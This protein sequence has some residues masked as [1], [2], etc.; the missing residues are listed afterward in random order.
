MHGRVG[1]GAHDVRVT[2]VPLRQP[3]VEHF[4]AARR[5]HHVRGLQIAVGQPRAVRGIERIRE[6]DRDPQ[7]VLEW[8]RAAQQPVGQRLARQI[9]HHQELD[10]VLLADVVQRADVRVR[11]A[12]DRA[13]F[14]PKAFL[15]PGVIGDARRQDLDRDGSIEPRVA[16][17]VDFA[18]AAGAERRHDF[19]RSQP[20]AWRQEH[21][22]C[23]SV[24]PPAVSVRKVISNTPMRIRSPSASCT[25]DVTAC[26]RTY[27]PFLLPRSSSVAISPVMT[28]LA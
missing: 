15:A 26:P 19:I 24:E 22:A 3:E 16:R 1:D 13:G 23:V 27:V 18:H 4:G 12:R 7:D 6:L 5:Q 2:A 17:F 11:Q 25:G 10:A 9:L 14:A 8:Q 21:G 20:C 28:I